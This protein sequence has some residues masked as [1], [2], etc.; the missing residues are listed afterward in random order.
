MTGQDK[1]LAIVRDVLCAAVPTLNPESITPDSSLVEDLPIDSV[2]FVS[3]MVNL[4]EKIGEEVDLFA[5]YAEAEQK[6]D[7]TI[8]SLIQHVLAR[9]NDKGGAAEGVG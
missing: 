9:L 2:Y 4:E 5:W 7:V 1:I 3:I 6:N 8:R